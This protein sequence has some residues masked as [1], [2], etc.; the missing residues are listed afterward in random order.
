M[1]ASKDKRKIEKLWKWWQETNWR[2]ECKQAMIQYLREDLSHGPKNLWAMVWTA[3]V[4]VWGVCW[5]SKILMHVSQQ[6]G[7]LGF[8]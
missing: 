1:I 5:I 6:A 7:L 8:I 4:Q 3:K 2:F